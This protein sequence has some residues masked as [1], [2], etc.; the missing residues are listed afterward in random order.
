MRLHSRTPPVLLCLWLLAAAPVTA[1]TGKIVSPENIPGASKVD[2]EGLLQLAEHVRDLV[3]VDARVRG[4]RE[5]GFIEESKSLPDSETNCKTLAKLIRSVDTPVLFYCNG[6]RCGR[7]VKSSQIA[8]DCGYRHIYWFRGGF[9]EWR[10]K[11]Y[12]YVRN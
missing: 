8:L 2:A 11:G 5:H 10:A 7:S 1:D 12:P 6:P 3:I 9:E 4:D